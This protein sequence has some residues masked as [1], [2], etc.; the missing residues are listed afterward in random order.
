M[1]PLD[2]A[3]PAEYARA[4][5]VRMEALLCGGSAPAAAD[6]AG[7]LR[8]SA[9]PAPAGTAGIEAL[10]A[11]A[12]RAAASSAS[13]AAAPYAA[14]MAA[15][16]ARAIPDEIVGVGLDYVRVLLASG[17]VDEAV[18]V[19]GRTAAF[20]DRDPRAAL[21]EAL[22]YAALGRNAEA[23]DAFGRV[24]RLAGE[25]AFAELPEHRNQTAGP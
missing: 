15:A 21:I 5:R 25:R 7:Q 3:H 17:H 19:N 16:T 24:R 14:A 23:D 9:G 6:A 20:A 8:A 2:T 13:V 10:R 12:K 11:D 4:L 18:S 22:V 1:Q